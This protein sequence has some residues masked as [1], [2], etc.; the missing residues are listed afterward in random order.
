MAFNEL[1]DHVGVVAG[2][3]IRL[4]RSSEAAAVPA[5][6]ELRP[7]EPAHNTVDGT[8]YLGKLDGSVATVPTAVGFQKIESLTQAAYDALVDATAT[9]STT[10]YIVT[11]N[12][13]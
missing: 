11:P 10:L 8:L 5:A 12:P 1:A 7:G 2:A 9:I 13:E 6:G 4:R 3:S